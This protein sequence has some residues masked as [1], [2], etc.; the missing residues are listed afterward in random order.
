MRKPWLQDERYFWKAGAGVVVALVVV[1]FFVEL[2][3]SPARGKNASEKQLDGEAAS[4][5]VFR[6]G[7]IKE[8]SGQGGFLS[9]NWADLPER[10]A[11]VHSQRYYTQSMKL[12]DD[13]LLEQSQALQGLFIAEAP[14][15]P[16]NRELIETLAARPE[17]EEGSEEGGGSP[18]QVSASEVKKAADTAQG[19]T[20]Q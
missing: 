5:E 7:G 1:V 15:K 17:G 6:T 18:S 19:G 20:G 2:F 8:S 3:H 10:A 13:R 16:L 4:T 12:R 14:E 9:T 11:P